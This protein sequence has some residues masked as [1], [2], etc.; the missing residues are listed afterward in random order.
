ME[1]TIQTIY[2]RMDNSRILQCIRSGLV[3][4]IPVLLIGSFSLVFRSLPIDP[5]Q[6]FITSFLSGAV[7]QLLTFIHNATFGFLAVY[8]TMAIAICYSQQ[9][10]TAYTFSY[11]PLFTSLVCFCIFSG[12]LSENFT[13]DA[14]GVNGMFTAIVC[15]L[16]ASSLYCYISKRLPRF[17]HL[18]TDGADSEFSSAIT[19]IV[20]SLSVIL[21]FALI[22]LFFVHYFSVSGFQFLV[23]DMINQIF[24]NMGRSPVSA[25]LFILISSILWF[26]GIHGSDVLDPVSQHIFQPAL[27]VNL[28]LLQNG[29]P[30]TEIF[31]KP[32]FDVFAFMGGCGT[33]LCL[34]LAI[35]LFGK[36]R[37]N[38]SLARLAALPMLFNINE[39]MVFGL[40]IVF[41]LLLLLP[42]LLTPLVMALTSGLAM[43]FGLVPYPIANVE[44]TTPVFLGG[45]MATGSLSGAA[46]QLFN[47]VVGTLIYRPFI[48]MLDAKKLSNAKM[49]I[50][51]LTKL[52]QKSEE[53]GRPLE[54]MTL[55][56]FLSNIPKALAEDITQRLQKQGPVLFYQPQYD[57]ENTCIGAEALLRWQ[58]PLYGTLYPPMV[59]KLAEE[60]GQLLHL[61]KEIFKAVTKDMGL[62]LSLIGK[63]A[64]VSVNVSGITIQTD[65]FEAF[66]SE[67]QKEHPEACRH[68]CIEITEQAALQ[69]NDTQISRLTRIHDMG[70][71]LAIDDFSMGSTSIKYLQS[72]VFDL[73]KLD[74]SL[75]RDVINNTRSRDIVASIAALSKNFGIQVLAEYV[76][77]KD[78]QKL[79]ESIGCCLYQGYLYSPAVPIQKLKETLRPHVETN[80]GNS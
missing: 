78:Q 63:N 26:F 41:N 18:Y 39:I 65:E 73:I 6:D 44:W 79:L 43:Y 68:I 54:L 76:E 22:N 58:N 4:M 61:E 16:G 36:N 42:F 28:Q 57:N 49:G 31:S 1:N 47:L 17:A 33:T 21:A 59:I 10:L 67:L 77:T 29:Q 24:S 56:G 32:F 74:G 15:S 38:H 20:P 11:G 27:D 8:M 46:L 66:L 64:T 45:Y 52:Y 51:N 7:Y 62:L 19:T 72:N 2:D 50:E 14:F 70:Y 60:T 48:K 55:R 25:M 71:S 3:M 9:N 35:V 34:L 30:A 12:L 69:I 5:Y 13:V 53:E 80:Q 23:V 75:S 37:S 40:P